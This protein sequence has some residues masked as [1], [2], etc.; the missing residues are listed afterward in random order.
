MKAIL[1]AVLCVLIAGVAFTVGRATADS[2]PD[3]ERPRDFVVGIGDTV[4]IPAVD[5]LC[6]AHIEAR[7]PR[8]LCGRTASGSRF[9]VA[10][11][12]RR[13]VVIPVGDPGQIRV[14]SER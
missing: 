4:R 5:A 10:F 8:F 14:F 9:Q 2:T 1:V 3:P 11:D 6:G 7:Q 12:P 13:T